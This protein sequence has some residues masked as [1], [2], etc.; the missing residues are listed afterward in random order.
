MN[1]IVFMGTP[2]FAVPALERLIAT[3]QVVGVVTQPDRPAGRGKTLRPPPVKEAALAA[4]LP[5]FQPRSLKKV[6]AA[7]PIRDWAPDLIV[8]AAFGQIL[9]PHLL[10]LPP[11]GC[12]NIHASLL[13]RW[14]GAAPI[15]AAILAGD[16]ETGITL[17]QMD[18]GLDTGP[19]L[20]QDALQIAPGETAG[21]LHDRLADLGADMIERY[22]PDLLA[23][24]LIGIPQDDE[25]ATYAGMIQKSDGL[26]NWHAPAVELERR[27]RAMAP[28]PGAFTFWSGKPLKIHHASADPDTSS[29]KPIGQVVS[30][31]AGIAVVT[32][33]GLLTLHVC[34]PPGKKPLPIEDFVRGR[35]SFLESNLN[36]DS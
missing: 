24:R 19:M 4:G 12:I 23:G 3:G 16:A 10:D 15:Q 2:D 27:V 36:N 18:V 32:G 31:P 17:M 7:Q 20:A 26:L 25:Q 29:D 1:R 21:S 33:R 34:Q 6:E 28:W 9:R 30:R 13:P 11:L 35:P 5:V 8:V 22:L 14:R